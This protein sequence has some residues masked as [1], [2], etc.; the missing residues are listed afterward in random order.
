MAGA[1]STVSFIGDDGSLIITDLL[2]SDNI[3]S[4]VFQFDKIFNATS[5]QGNLCFL[6]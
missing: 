1:Q 3:S 4:K 2:A 5:S 6:S